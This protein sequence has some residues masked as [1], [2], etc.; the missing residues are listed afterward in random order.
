MAHEVTQV[1][2]TAR[3]TAVV[4]RATTWAE[5]PALWPVLL[6]EVR[7]LLSDQTGLNV[8]LYLD[9]VPNVEVGVLA[10][11][12]FAP[13]GRVT[14]SWLPAGAAAM[15]VHR[16]PYSE[17]DAAHRAV[18]DW[19]AAQGLART[20]VRFEIYGHHHDDPA[21]CVTEVHHLLA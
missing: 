4:A 1:M 11:A 14:A 6:G 8:M 18:L 2:G 20:G 5:F 9:D 3:P 7:A 19:C 10:D 21:Q 15:T 17:L 12:A 16:G 13:R